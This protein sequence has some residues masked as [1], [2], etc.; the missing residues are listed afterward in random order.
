VWDEEKKS[1]V[2]DAANKLA[3]KILERL[4]MSDDGRTDKTHP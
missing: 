3:A 4:R 2:R 1:Q